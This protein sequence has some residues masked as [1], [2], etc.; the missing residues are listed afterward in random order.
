[1]FE[2]RLG[3]AKVL[4]CCMQAD[5]GCRYSVAYSANLSP[6]V[7]MLHNCKGQSRTVATSFLIELTHLNRSTTELNLGGTH[8]IVVHCSCA[9]KQLQGVT[10]QQKKTYDG[11]STWVIQSL[12]NAAA[13][14]TTC[15]K[16][17]CWLELMFCL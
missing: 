3:A 10:I 2:E 6:L 12:C 1:M 13:L 9:C 14:H 7:E 5:G 11:S 15:S 16:E 8:R 4:C 17:C